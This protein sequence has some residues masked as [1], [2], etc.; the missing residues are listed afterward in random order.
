MPKRSSATISSIVVTPPA[1]V[2]DP[3]DAF[4]QR[5]C[6]GKVDAAEHSFALDVGVKKARAVRLQTRG[7]LGRGFTRRAT[8]SVD[9][10]VS[11]AR[12]ERNEHAIARELREELL[13]SSRAD[14]DR[15]G[16]AA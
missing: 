7:A 14:D 16:A 8:P 10:D 15:D 13:A 11:V 12:I 3:L 6:G 4:T 9:G 5:G 2:S 1:K